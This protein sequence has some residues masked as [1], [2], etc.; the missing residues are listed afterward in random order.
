VCIYMHL[1]Y[2]DMRTCTGMDVSLT[3]AHSCMSGVG[4]HICIA[5]GCTH[6]YYHTHIHTCTHVIGTH[7]VE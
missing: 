3:Y 1:W 7:T 4:V 2:M 6:I 5:I